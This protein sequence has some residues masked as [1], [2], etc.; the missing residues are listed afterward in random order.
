VNFVLLGL[1]V[2]KVSH[3][4]LA[5]YIEQHILTPEHVTHTSLPAGAAFPSPHATGYTDIE[6]LALGSACGTSRRINSRLP[7]RDHLPA[8][9]AGHGRGAHQQRYQ[10]PS[11]PGSRSLRGRLGRPC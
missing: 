2:E 10:A 3:Q 11:R 9:R 5:T 6:C 7:K 8:R 1:V 4:P